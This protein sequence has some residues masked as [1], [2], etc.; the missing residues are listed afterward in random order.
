MTG[1]VESPLG[2]SVAR[3]EGL[4]KV[5]GRVRY[6]FEHDVQG[7]HHGWIVTS[8]VPAGTITGVDVASATALPG[9]VGVVWHG[10]APHLEDGG[11]GELLVLQSATVAYTGQ[12]VAVV[13][14]TSAE[15]ARA[16]ADALVVRIDETSH[17]TE[18]TADDAQ[19]YAPESLNAG[20]E[21]DTS[22]GDVEQALQ[23]AAF[24]VDQTYR[25]APL[26][27]APMEPHASI[28][29]WA[30]DGKVSLWDS[31]QAPSEVATTTATMFG[32][33]EGAVT[34]HARHIGGGFGGKGSTRPN[35]VLAVM[36]AKVTG[37]PVKIALTRQMAFH[38]VGYRTPTIQHVRVGADAD[39]TLVALS[40]EIVEQ[41]SQIEEFAEQTGESTRH[42]YASPNRFV[43]HRLA[44]L[45]V[46]TPRW[47]RAP[48]EAPGMFAME[49]AL[50][51]LAR[52]AG[53]DP[54]ALRIRNET[55]VD[56]AS[57]NRFSS[58]HYVECLQEGARRFG[59]GEPHERRV[60]RHLVGH[61]VAGSIYP[62]L[63]MP[64][65]ARAAAFD[66]GSFE[67]ALAATDIGQGSR[68]VLTQIAADALGVG[69]DDV[70]LDLGDS[71]LPQAAGAGGSA[72]TASWGWAITVACRKLR[73]QLGKLDG[74]PRGGLAVE[75]SNQDGIDAQADL[76][77]FAFGA[78]FVEVHVDAESGEV[79]VPRAVGVFA[80]GRILNP[81]LARSQFI[82]AMTMGIGMG[83]ME[84]GVWDA[85]YGD[86]VNDDFASYHIPSNADIGEI[87]V[88]W[89][90]EQDDH[91]NP[92]GSKGIGEIGIV[93]MAAAL[94]NAVFD[95]TGVRV[96]DLPI[97]LDHLL[98]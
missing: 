96:R 97:R 44:T 34:V 38:F 59:W 92:M 18:L 85:R 15:A 3:V 8:P 98:S 57:G 21:T 22:E 48:G 91:L 90:D 78:Q 73:S 19:L 14:A 65:T 77:R 17:R 37:H 56:P 68:T 61:G 32:L 86:T 93:G 83:L 23:E 43:T 26:H 31:T 29:L 12:P 42:L 27:N 63:V 54:V 30:A 87:D 52:V 50:D 84:E 62:K 88:S 24:V 40:H 60:G 10:N 79:R 46:P 94:A 53:I 28:A 76:A 1:L 39:G 69:L 13:V 80:P 2:H 95:A 82:G 36:A 89:I 55:A 67:V 51:E 70:R 75:G 20:F 74:I 9:V 25:T 5:A 41:T 64:S 72:G 66:D 6:A 58:R 81:R 35:A 49:S 47:M 7:V 33:D 11:D 71:S 45:N 16:G 4:D